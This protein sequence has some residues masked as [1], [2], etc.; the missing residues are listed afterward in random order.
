M[1]VHRQQPALIRHHLGRQHGLSARCR[2]QIKHR[3]AGFW[4]QSLHTQLA[5][6]ILN[7]KQALL[8]QITLQHALHAV[9]DNGVGQIG[10]RCSRDSLLC[11]LQQQ[12]LPGRF[13]R[14]DTS[15][16][17]YRGI[18]GLQQGFTPGKAQTLV[19]LSGKP[20]GMAVANGKIIQFLFPGNLRQIVQT[21]LQGAQ[22]AVC[23]TGSCGVGGLFHQFHRLVD[24]SAVG[25]SGQKHQLIGTQTQSIQH[26]RG[27]FFQRTG[28]KLTQQKIQIS[29]V[30]QHTVCNGGSQSGFLRTH[31]G[32]S[33]FQVQIRPCT[34]PAEGDQGAERRFT[35]TQHQSLLFRLA[36]SSSRSS[37]DTA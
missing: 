6:D 11:K 7:V 17:R 30:L 9:K 22:H 25:N 36:I 35:S 10:V 31:I 19:H 15:R 18:V 33:F 37:C 24:G 32:A 26:L 27:D 16:H 28:R 5:G 20:F 4:L 34:F 3:L 13:Q 14:I 2:T 29:P 21:A 8:Q 23:I 1:D 12:L